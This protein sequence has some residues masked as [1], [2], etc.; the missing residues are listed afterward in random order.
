MMSSPASPEMVP[1][2]VMSTSLPPFPKLY[3]IGLSVVRVRFE[4]VWNSADIKISYRNKVYIECYI[5]H[6]INKYAL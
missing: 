4:N 6:A 3:V 5:S 2:S 1:A